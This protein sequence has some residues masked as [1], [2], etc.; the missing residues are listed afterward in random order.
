MAGCSFR[1]IW[2]LTPHHSVAFSRTFPVVERRWRSACV[3]DGEV[4][5]QAPLPSD[6]EVAA[7]FTDRKQREGSA[8]GFGICVASSTPGSDSWVDD[9]VTRH[10]ITLHINR[11]EAEGYM[12]WPVIVHTSGNYY[13]LVLPLVEPKKVRE[14]RKLYQRNNCGGSVKEHDNLSS[15]LLSLPCITGAFMVAHA[16]G[17][18]IA[19]E[20]SDPEVVATSSSS[21]VGGLLDTLT[22][23]IGIGVAPRPKPTSVPILASASSAAT[24]MGSTLV[25]SSRTMTKPIDKDLLRGFISGSMPYGTPVD[26]N[27]N[28]IA[29][30]RTTGFGSADPPPADLRQPAWKPYLYRGRQRVLLMTQETINAALYDRE[31]IPDS[32]SISGQINCRAELE[33][34]PDVQLPLIGVK[35][36][37]VKMLSVHQSAQ[38]SDHGEDKQAIVF[39]PPV[40]SF[41][42]AR[43]QVSHATN[44]APVKGFYQLS[45]V[46]ED[47]GQFLFRLTLME[48][49]KSPYCMDFCTIIMPF[50]RRRILSVDGTPSVG[51]VSMT[52]RSIEW[53]IVTSGRGISGKTIDATFSGTVRFHPRVVNK[54][55]S[56]SLSKSVLGCTAAEDSDEERE[57]SNNSVNV[58]DVL[59][60]KLNRDLE[61][62][63]LEEPL[64][65]QAFNYAKVSFKIT[66]GTFS[67]MTI[68]PKSVSI[69]PVVKAP[70]EYSMQVTS[71][72][73]ILWNTLAR[74]PHA[75]VPKDLC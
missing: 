7:A 29:A 28:N 10:I 4:E 74:S 2:I 70:V 30:I 63:D 41:V 58:E 15:L 57:S 49:Y 12:L 46:S 73:Y 65:W 31:D 35:P 68:D 16:I 62:V 3:R 37:K 5:T 9:P 23:S 71:G 60:E 56:V 45:L 17:D 38:Y 32:F 20:T 8:R 51:T 61:A 1:A 14:Y 66:G 24:L 44:P 52:E 11:E 48:G 67:G 13:I 27:Q 18:L 72:D 47:G 64:C 22:G 50:P 36:A 69:Y 25:D 54:S 33:G 19:G 55:L 21:A 6:L 39:S 43:Y 40:G 53:K 59:M 26:L 75:A 42:L 34:L